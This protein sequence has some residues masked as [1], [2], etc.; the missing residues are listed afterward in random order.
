MTCLY[1]KQI[2]KTHTFIKAHPRGVTILSCPDTNRPTCQ[3]RLLC[4]AWQPSV[5]ASS[6]LTLPSSTNLPGHSRKSDWPSPGFSPKG[7]LTSTWLAFASIS[8]LCMILTLIRMS[9]VIPWQLEILSFG[10]VRSVLEQQLDL[11]SIHPPLHRSTHFRLAS[12][13]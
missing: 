1:S 3:T 5:K 12:K 2:E 9:V 10:V 6:F 7:D 8:N 11:G 4:W 13:I